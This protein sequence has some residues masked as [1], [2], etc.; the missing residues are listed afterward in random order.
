MKINKAKFYRSL[1]VLGGSLRE[2]IE[3]NEH[4]SPFDEKG[5][6]HNYIREFIDSWLNE[7]YKDYCQKLSYVERKKLIDNIFEYILA[8]HLLLRDSDIKEKQHDY[9]YYSDLYLI[10]T[11]ENKYGGKYLGTSFRDNGPFGSLPL[12]DDY[13]E[14]SE[15]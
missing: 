11:N 4:S 5:E 3:M 7:K 8:E 12:Y 14:E 10:N 1:V 6:L 9:D 15:S 13:S 2:I